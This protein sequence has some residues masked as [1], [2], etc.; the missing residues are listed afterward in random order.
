V[1]SR[2]R[3][4]LPPGPVAAFSLQVGDAGRSEQAWHER[5]AARVAGDYVEWIALLEWLTVDRT[6]QHGVALELRSCSLP[7]TTSS[8][9][10]TIGSRRAGATLGES[11]GKLEP[12]VAESG[13]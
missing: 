11:L 4:G 2:Q 1:L 12:Y 5:V 3:N 10:A 8:L 13:A 7:V 6:A 9:P